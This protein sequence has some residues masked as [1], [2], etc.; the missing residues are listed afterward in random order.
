M[1]I[2]KHAN[3]YMVKSEEDHKR[4]GSEARVY[5]VGG[6]TEGNLMSA[7]LLGLLENYIGRAQVMRLKGRARHHPSQRG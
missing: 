7:G 3:L 1:D 4:C 5:N 6:S 2:S